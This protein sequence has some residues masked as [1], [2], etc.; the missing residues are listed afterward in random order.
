MCGW[1][2]SRKERQAASS[3]P[4]DAVITYK[5]LFPDE[6][7]EESCSTSGCPGGLAGWRAGGLAG[8]LPWLGRPARLDGGPLALPCSGLAPGSLL[9]PEEIPRAST[10]EFLRRRSRQLGNRNANVSRV[11]TMTRDVA[12]NVMHV[13][14]ER[15]EREMERASRKSSCAAGTRGWRCRAPAAPTSAGRVTSRR[16]AGRWRGL[17]VGRVMY[18]CVVIY[19]YIYMYI[20]THCIYIYIYTIFYIINCVWVGHPTVSR[21]RR[22]PGTIPC[23]SRLSCSCG[24]AVFVSLPQAHI[25]DPPQML[26]M[27]SIDLF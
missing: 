4:Q 20:Y 7:H 15:G 12:A 24:V 8:W 3:R 14:H 5:E 17:A 22:L 21:E 11:Q 10:P 19:I 13:S 1:S 6:N 2:D 16:A 27:L 25:C 9:V 23:G 18:I 26:S